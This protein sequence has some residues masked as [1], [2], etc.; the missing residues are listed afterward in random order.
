MNKLRFVEVSESKLVFYTAHYGP[1][2]RR[3]GRVG[4]EKG[5]YVISQED[6]DAPPIPLFGADGKESPGLKWSQCY[7]SLGEAETA[8]GTTSRQAE[9][10]LAPPGS[11]V[12]IA[13][14]AGGGPMTR[15]RALEMAQECWEDGGYRDHQMDPTLAN[16]IANKLLSVAGVGVPDSPPAPQPVAG[17][18]IDDTPAPSAPAAPVAPAAPPAAKEKTRAS[19]DRRQKPDKAGA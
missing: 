8:A 7:R 9:G 2:R 10:E 18:V 14:G 4:R 15:D 5:F 17:P 1:N 6:D 11:V 19:G 3:R 12:A 16:A 13:G